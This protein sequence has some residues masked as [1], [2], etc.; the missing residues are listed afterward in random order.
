MQQLYTPEELIKGGWDLSA[1]RSVP[2]STYNAGKKGNTLS[3]SFAN[4]TGS[5]IYDAYVDLRGNISFLKSRNAG[6]FYSYT[7]Y[8]GTNWIRFTHGGRCLGWTAI[9]D[10]SSETSQR[11]S[12]LAESQ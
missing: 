12:Q 1:C 4:D 11:I 7:T 6:E 9:T 10:K 2:S 8:L 5:G 3:I